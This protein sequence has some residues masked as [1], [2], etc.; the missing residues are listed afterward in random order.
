VVS[1]VRGEI[2]WRNLSFRYD[3]DAPP[4]LQGISL[5]IPA[6]TW[7]GVVGETGAGKSTLVSLLPRL[8]EPPPGTIF[9]DGIELREL[10]LQTL[11]QA[12]GYVSQDIF[13]FSETIRENI[14]FGHG[15]ATSEELETA[16][17]LAQLTP[18][19]LEFTHQFDTLL[20]ERGVRLSGGQKQRTALARAII[21]NSPI[22]ILD[23][24]FSSVDIETEERILE[25]LKG[26]MR[27]RTVIL[28]SHRISTVMEADQIVYLQDGQIVERGSHE[29][30]LALRG[31]YY[32]LYRRQLLTRELEALSDNGGARR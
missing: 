22:L 16:A 25:Q 12:I 10:P 19:I 29:E 24:A 17:E 3:P 13:L 15:G 31:H 28:I 2:E 23:D 7:C 6:G 9:I 5:T 20:G 11:K 14:L 8:Y 30:L 21:K 26:F 1:K 18:S 32:R 4:A 27:E